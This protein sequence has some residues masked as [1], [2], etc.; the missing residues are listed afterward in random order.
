PVGFNRV[1][2]FDEE[3]INYLP[4]FA[5]FSFQAQDLRKSSDVGEII[6]F[7]LDRLGQIFFGLGPIVARNINVRQLDG[8]G[9]RFGLLT[10]LFQKG[11]LSFFAVVEW[12]RLDESTVECLVKLFLL[13][14]LPSGIL[15]EEKGL[16]PAA[17]IMVMF[18]Q[19][20]MRLR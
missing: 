7:E 3:I 12:L 9:E 18:S 17:L 6:R 16:Q 11:C 1:R 20:L 8:H 13:E 10:E 15:Q 19:G 2:M 5:G 14:E 4:R